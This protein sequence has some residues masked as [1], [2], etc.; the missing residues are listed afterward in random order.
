LLDLAQGGGEGALLVLVHGRFLV[1]KWNG[2]SLSAARLGGR[3]RTDCD[4]A[5]EACGRTRTVRPA[6]C[7]AAAADAAPARRET[8]RG[9]AAAHRFG[10]T[11]PQYRPSI[12]KSCPGCTSMGAKSGLRG[13]RRIRSLPIFS[14]LT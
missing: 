10:L 3:H 12:A 9:G 6:G 1:R 7:P 4:G 8:P 14:S 11:R 13:S 5:R 2:V